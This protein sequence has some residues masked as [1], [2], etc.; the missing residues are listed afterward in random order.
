VASTPQGESLAVSCPACRGQHKKHTCGK[1]NRGP[2]QEEKEKEK[3]D[4]GVPISEHV[5]EEE[6]PPQELRNE[7][8]EDDQVAPA[9]PEPPVGDFPLAI[10]RIHAK[11]QDKVELHKLHLKHYHMTPSQF[12]RRTQAL[13]LPE[14]IQKKYEEVCQ[15]CEVC[16]RLAPAPSR[17]RVSGLRA[18]EFGDLLFIDHTKVQ[19]HGKMGIIFVILDGATNLLW[20][21]AQP[22][23]RNETTLQSLR[24][25]MDQ[26][27][28]RP[29]GILAD[30]AFSHPMFEK[31]YRFHGI[32]FYSTGPRTSGYSRDNTN[33]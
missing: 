13:R 5:P 10:R 23:E 16:S 28:C 18:Q 27:Q 31:F 14:E 20:A 3:E 15:R 30:M 21:R 17:S 2:Q 4:P 11:L 26:Y 25:W 6:E 12:K 7:P 29:R 19:V 9:I 32:R 8:E 22:D 24:D 33:F 1:G